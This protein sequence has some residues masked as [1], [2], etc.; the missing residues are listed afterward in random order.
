[1]GVCLRAAIPF[2]DTEEM[3]LKPHSPFVIAINTEAHGAQSNA[4]FKDLSRD[5]AIVGG[6]GISNGSLLILQH[7]ENPDI[8][9]Y[10]HPDNI[11]A[12][13]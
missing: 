6:T 11:D 7:N 3:K 2:P 12:N 13:S 9:L 1:M 8:K 4:K 5:W 10:V